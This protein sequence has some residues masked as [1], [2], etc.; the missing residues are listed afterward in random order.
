MPSSETLIQKEND[1]EVK[2]N[3]NES[4]DN[5]T[6]DNELFQTVDSHKQQFKEYLQTFERRNS[7]SNCVLNR[8][9]SCE[10][11]NLADEIKKLS[12]RLMMLSSIN[13][14]LNSYNESLTTDN[15]N[16]IASLKT[17]AV[18]PES[19]GKDISR[20]EQE[21]NLNNKTFTEKELSNREKK[22]FKDKPA[23]KEKPAELVKNL[24]NKKS[25]E[26][27]F[28]WSIT[29]NSDGSKSSNILNNNNNRT[30]RFSRA[31][32]M[33]SSTSTSSRTYESNGSTHY[34][35]L[36]NGGLS[37]RLKFLDETPTLSQKL[38]N[39]R[40][41]SENISISRG[42]N[43]RSKFEEI[44]Q[45]TS[46]PSIHGSA[47]WPVTNRRTKFRITQLS[48]DVPIGSPDKHRTVFLEEAVTTTK[49]CLL[50]LLDKYN[51]NDTRAAYSSMGRHQSMSNGVSLTDNLEYRSMNSLNY[52]FQRHATAGQTVKQMQAQLES[53][54]KF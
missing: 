6:N 28:S 44:I 37:E 12:E 38:E 53:K 22:I 50:H 21:T 29:I 48:R 54:R 26:S 32:S 24:R 1:V 52:F 4:L 41:I 33:V 45:S 18:V 9:S 51:E 47:P 19:N 3:F 36:S 5:K 16:N 39:A 40:K 7:D 11:I 17:L 46:P 15:N 42:K 35:R 49:D 31:I 14:D 8:S 27:F 34:D 43:Y 25:D 30:S 23:I 2:M 20:D 10:K 13:N